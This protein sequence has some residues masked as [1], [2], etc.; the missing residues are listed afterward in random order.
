MIE[1]FAAKVL[2]VVPPAAAVNNA[3]VTCNVIDTWRADYLKVDVIL[4]ATD[5]ALTVLKLQESD[6]KASATSLT[7]GTDIVGTRFGT[8]DNDT[9]SLSTLPSST[10]DDH[11][12]SFFMDLR[13]H[14]RYVLPVITVG[15]GSTG[16]FVTVLATLFRN[17]EGP[18]LAT[19][20]GY[21]Q[22]MVL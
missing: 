10:D 4:G 20:A 12:F 8:D 11:V 18:R 7:G 17:A 2:N 14:K 19:D 15:D 21:T 9:G 22:R 6:V 1:A 13:G 3:S 5:I 16:A